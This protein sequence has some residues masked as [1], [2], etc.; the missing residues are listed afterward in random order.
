MEPPS[1]T[2]PFMEAKLSKLWSPAAPCPSLGTASFTDTVTPSTEHSSTR[3]HVSSSIPISS[4]HLSHSSV[5]NTNPL[6]RSSTGQSISNADW[7]NIFAAPLDPSVLGALPANGILNQASPGHYPHH[8]FHINSSS[9]DLPVFMPLGTHRSW[10][11]SPATHV[12]LHAETTLSHPTTAPPSRPY[13]NTG[14]VA[15]VGDTRSMHGRQS[16]NILTNSTASVHEQGTSTRNTRT[17]G[18]SSL[19]R[20]VF[21]SNSFEQSPAF[22]YSGEHSNIGL[23]PSLWMSP[24]SSPNSTSCGVLNVASMPALPDTSSRRS[25]I[26]QSPISPVSASVDSKSTLFTDIF[27]DE[28][29]PPHSA[30]LSPS[31]TTPFTSPR[32]AGSPVLQSADLDADPNKLAKEDPLAT[33][34]WRMYART[35]AGLPHAQRMENI[36][37]RMMALTLKKRKDDEGSRL[38]EKDDTPQKLDSQSDSQP[39]QNEES[40]ERGRRIDKGKARVRVVGFEGT[41]EDGIEEPDV[42]PMDWRA[43]SRSRSRISMDWRPAS[44]SRSRLPNSVISFEHP[45]IYGYDYRF[46]HMDPTLNDATDASKANQ[47]LEKNVNGKSSGSSHGIPIPGG[48]FSST[49]RRSPSSSAKEFHSDFAGIHED[50]GALSFDSNGELRHT[51]TINLSH[52]LSTFSS[53]TF[54]P[55]S[56]PST[57]LHGLHR[58]YGSQTHE[59]RTFPRHVRK[60]SFDHTVSKDGILQGVSGRHQVNGKPLSPDS[61]LGQ[62]RRAEAPHR[63]SMLRADPSNVPTIVHQEQ[64]MFERNSPFPTSTFDFTFPPCEN[65]L[66]ISSSSFD[67]SGQAGLSRRDGTESDNPQ[68]YNPARS[69]V[70]GSIFSTVGSPIVASEGLSPA[71][72]AAS[73]VIAEGYAQINTTNL[74]GTDDSLLDYHLMNLAYPGLDSS[75]VNRNTYTHVDPQIL[76]VQQGE[77]ATSFNNFHSSPSSDGWANGFSSSTGASPEPNNA[78][79]SASTPPSVE[80]MNDVRSV[81]G[82]AAGQTSQHQRKYISLKQGP[83]DSHEILNPSLHGEEGRS[84]APRTADFGG[85]DG[86]QGISSKG[87]VEDGEQTPTLCTNCQT[88]NTPLWR[89]NPEGQPLCNACGLFYKLHG[90]VRPLS[91][92]TDIIKKR[93]RASNSVGGNA[94]K[95]VSTLPKIASSTSRPRS[96]SGSLLSGVGRGMTSNLRSDGPTLAMKRQRRTSHGMQIPEPDT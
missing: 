62:K 91:L 73:A 48:M 37:W 46:S 82:L 45:S 1:L 43:F 79:S 41:S 6:D 78:A 8:S 51:H 94:R 5:K 85:K 55:S 49:A 66:S 90:V 83:Q 36:T 44:R 26:V 69:P 64:D 17:F 31:A 72:A 34:V 28:L 95:N 76:S 60:T 12:A 23:P 58:T 40:N 22:P 57:G 13:I 47:S 10:S 75:N 50:A 9:R 14:K 11:Q 88:T 33:Q 54:G 80:V 77:S 65:L 71:A 21:D 4:H 68:V 53:P 35:K 3:L 30:S 18:T 87:S 70:S 56:L 20:T 25:N 2:R 29:F 32:V 81:G 67:P 24:V 59:P 63:D 42:V 15:R 89:R 38:S 96:Q 92:K 74:G 52:P 16:R 19:S 93:N 86:T 39:E 7:A 84:I 61:L 27:S